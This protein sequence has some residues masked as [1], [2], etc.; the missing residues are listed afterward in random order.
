M[1]MN[2]LN[3]KLK[4]YCAN[5]FVESSQLYQRG[6]SMYLQGARPHSAEEICV[7]VHWPFGLSECKDKN[8]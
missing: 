6:I 8:W 5:I 2:D 7:L 3:F 4:K 1:S